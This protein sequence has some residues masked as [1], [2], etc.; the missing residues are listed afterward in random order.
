[1]YL[2]Y[3]NTIEHKVLIKNEQSKI[4]NQYITLLLRSTNS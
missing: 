4:Q 3:P 2:F 1:M